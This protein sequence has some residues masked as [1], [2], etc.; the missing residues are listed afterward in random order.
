MW[1]RD[2]CNI[3]V[4]PI[5]LMSPEGSRHIV[6]YTRHI[7]E[8]AHSVPV[9]LVTEPIVVPVKISSLKRF[10]VLPPFSAIV[11][12]NVEIELPSKLYKVVDGMWANVTIV[13]PYVRDNLCGL[14]KLLNLALDVDSI[15]GIPYLCLD[16]SFIDCKVS[17]HIV[18]GG[19]IEVTN[20]LE[21]GIV[22][23]IKIE[24]SG[25]PL[26]SLIRYVVEDYRDKPKEQTVRFRP[27]TVDKNLKIYLKPL[28]F[29][30]TYLVITKIGRGVVYSLDISTDL[31]RVIYHILLLRTFTRDPNL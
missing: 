28:M 13:A 16:D 11:C 4:F 30:N 31:T 1:I 5:D 15:N 14:A 26:H 18:G 20:M 29:I 12:N 24:N 7:F 19:F 17:R 23:D 9:Y 10:I 21:E 25:E 6:A 8:L 27:I 3:I 2:G 22:S